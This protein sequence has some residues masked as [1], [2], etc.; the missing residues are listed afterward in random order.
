MVIYK[1]YLQFVFSLYLDSKQAQSHFNM[2]P[3]LQNGLIWLLGSKFEL[4][5]KNADGGCSFN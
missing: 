4:W 5:S 2:E 3:E 1:T